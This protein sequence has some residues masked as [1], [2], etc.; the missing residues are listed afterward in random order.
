MTIVKFRLLT[1]VYPT[2]KEEA[3]DS[4]KTVVPIYQSSRLCITGERFSS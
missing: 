2:L 3:A 1:A 4:S